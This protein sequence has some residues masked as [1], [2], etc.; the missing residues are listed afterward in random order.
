MSVSCGRRGWRLPNSSIISGRE[1]SISLWRWRSV[2]D[3]KRSFPMVDLKAVLIRFRPLNDLSAEHDLTG[4]VQRICNRI[5]MFG[6]IVVTWG[7]VKDGEFGREDWPCSRSWLFHFKYQQWSSLSRL[8][9]KGISLS[10]ML[11]NCR[12]LGD[13][14]SMIFVVRMEGTET[15]LAEL[16]AG[17]C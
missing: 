10:Y 6:N 5:L 15:S 16:F 11:P 8:E 4:R 17:V 7:N 3:V 1:M 2:S 14:S 12:I 9:K 13:T